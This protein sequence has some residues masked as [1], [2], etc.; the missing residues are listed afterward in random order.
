MPLPQSQKQKDIICFEPNWNVV[1][2]FTTIHSNE[3]IEGL[4]NISIVL[5]LVLMHIARQ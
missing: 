3:F 5:V 2:N 4:A 1:R